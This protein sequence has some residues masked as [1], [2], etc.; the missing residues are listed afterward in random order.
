M[1]KRWK[2]IGIT[3]CLFLTFQNIQGQKETNLLEKHEITLLQ[4]L[5][6]DTTQKANFFVNNQFNF[7][8]DNL[9]FTNSNIIKDG[10][11]IYIQPLGTGIIYKVKNGKNSIQL[12]R[13]DHTIHSGVNFYAQNFMVRDT[14]FQYGGIG[15]WQIRGIITYYSQNTNEWELIQTN[16]TVPSF[17]DDHKDAIVH[18]DDNKWNAKMYVSNAYYY[19]DYPNTF[20]SNAIDSCYVFD[21]NNRLWHTLGKT[22][23]QF[24]A[25]FNTK[26]AKNFELHLNNL[27]VFQNQ[28]EFYWLDFEKNKF[29]QF[30]N[31]ES[32][33][34]RQLWLSFYNNDKTKQ[35]TQFQF[36]IGNDL[37]FTKMNP[38]EDM[39]WI[40]T[41]LQLSEINT[42]KAL[43]IYLNNP[44]FAEITYT[45]YSK[46]RMYILIVIIAFMLFILLRTK[47]L[48]RKNI[49]KEITTILYQNFFNSITVIEKE[50][51]EALYENN[52]N[53]DELSTKVI[54][55]I[56]GVQQKD[57]LTQN[58]S[59]S[60]YFIKMNQKFKMSTQQPE[61]FII[62]NR[63]KGDKRQFNYNLNPIYIKE[64]EKLLKVQ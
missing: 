56:I 42:N 18:V 55:K 34:L 10:K 35:Q 31:K 46:Y 8:L 62:K 22:N 13:I 1:I 54:N 5:L 63:D 32:D 60:D 58:K 2:K 27:F 51:I 45:I 59:R 15:F 26:S 28:L 4:I 33:R 50:L 36:N 11:A 12:E 64:I 41:S 30:S 17:F 52:I 43:P 37:Y 29:G 57:T 21:F 3:L 38:G 23:P 25:L 14:L 7:G 20:L 19:P 49:P 61:A 48:K 9:I 16:K 39:Q 24:K 53:G 6:A 40:K 47:L 44:S